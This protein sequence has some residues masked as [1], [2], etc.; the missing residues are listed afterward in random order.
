MCECDVERDYLL[1]LAC[2]A[3]A[4]YGVYGVVP[5]ELGVLAEVGHGCVGVDGPC[6]FG[7]DEV[8]ESQDGK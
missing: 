4:E 8:E 1:A 7:A 3:L 2:E 6:G 5:F